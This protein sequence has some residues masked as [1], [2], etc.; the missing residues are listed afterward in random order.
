MYMDQQWGCYQVLMGVVLCYINYNDNM[1]VIIIVS[2]IM[3]F[4]VFVQDEIMLG[5][6]N[7]LFMGFC[8]DSYN[9]YGVVW[10]LCFGFYY[11]FNDN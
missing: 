4:G 3:L 2:Q 10:L 8:L 5:E 7:Y 9:E 11:Y 6:Y 1:F